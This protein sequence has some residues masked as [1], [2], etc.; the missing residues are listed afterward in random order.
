MLRRPG[1]GA[2]CSGVFN[3]ATVQKVSSP[4]RAVGPLERSRGGIGGLRG[5]ISQKPKLGHG[6]QGSFLIATT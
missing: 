2:A 1:D 5:E 3:T 6:V 4:S